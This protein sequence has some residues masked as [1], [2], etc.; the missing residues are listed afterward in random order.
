MPGY[1][2]LG[3][4][5]KNALIQIFEQSNGI[6]YRYGFDERR[7]N[8]FRVHEFEEAIKN[9]LKARYAH[10]TS[11]GTAA[12]I[13]SLHALG[14]EPGD[15]VITQ[16]HT[17]IATVEAILAVGALPVIANIDKT[18]NMDPKSFKDLITEKTK[19]VIPVHMLGCAADLFTIESIARRHDIKIL[20][21]NAQSFGGTLG[22]YFLGTYGDIGITSFDIGKTITTGEGGMIFTNDEELYKKA[23]AVTDHG[24]SF[25]PN[26]TRAEDTAMCRGYNFKMTEMQGAVG[27]AQIEKLGYI[28]QRQRKNKEKILQGIRDIPN[29]ELRHRI[30]PD[31]DIG[32][33]VTFFFRDHYKA[34]KFVKEWRKLGHTTKNIPDALN[35][36]FAAFWYHLDMGLPFDD[37][38]SS[39]SI[40]RRAVTIP[41]YVK[42]TDQD[43][44]ILV[45]DIMDITKKL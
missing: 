37:L 3:D 33:S 15:E 12:L 36:H 28:L 19:V 45:K 34:K 35:W 11:S 24:H 32:D 2:L 29:I 41:V 22:G 8:I 42:M 7:N 31:G 25:L 18:L 4:E 38:E 39:Y 5:E 30:D 43:I 13:A 9:K 44:S 6:L 1:E 40:L 21:D 23:R 26:K 27:L 16:S 10:A 14:V 20:E 17:F